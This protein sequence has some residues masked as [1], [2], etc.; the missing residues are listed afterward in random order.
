VPDALRDRVLQ[1]SL[2]ARPPGRYTPPAPRIRPVE[3]FSRAASALDHLLSELRGEEWHQPVLR[4][5]DVQGLVGHLIGVEDDVRRGLAGDEAVGGADH[6]VSTQATALRQSGLPPEVTLA[7]WREAV[8]ATRLLIAAVDTTAHSAGPSR[9][10]PAAVAL[11]GMRVPPGVL[12]VVRAFELWT[13]ENDVRRATG[14]PPSVPDGATLTLM[15]GVATTALPTGADRIGLTAAID[16]RL[17]LTGPGGGAWSI[18]LGHQRWKGSEPDDAPDHA[19]PDDG[20]LRV[21]IVTDAVG[22]CRLAAARIEPHD[23]DVAVTGSESVAYQ[24]LA[25]TAALALD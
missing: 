3:A 1:A 12:L 5:L 24:V 23:L 10:A 8:R 4:G 6:V 20:P 19:E 17:V 22:F 18:R 15:T 16:V 7:Q 21:R 13:H 25:A 11:H 2:A 9:S 14:R